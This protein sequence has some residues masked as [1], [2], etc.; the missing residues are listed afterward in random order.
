MNWWKRY[1]FQCH[2]KQT[3]ERKERDLLWQNKREISSVS[4]YF[5]QQYF[6]KVFDFFQLLF[7]SKMCELSNGCQLLF[8]KLFSKRTIVES[9]GNFTILNI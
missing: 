5:S 2:K 8:K 9:H 4:K 7:Y 1:N 6:G 3:Y